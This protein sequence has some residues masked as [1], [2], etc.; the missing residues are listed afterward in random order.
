MA[1]AKVYRKPSRISAPW[2][3]DLAGRGLAPE[4]FLKLLIAERCATAGP[5]LVVGLVV[6]VVDRLTW[7]SWSA[8]L[9]GLTRAKP[10]PWLACVVGLTRAKPWPLVGVCR[11]LLSLSWPRLWLPGLACLGWISTCAGHLDLEPG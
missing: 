2:P 1:L 4:V 8:Y 3:P 11:R 6:V 9:V 7:V 10:W 5:W